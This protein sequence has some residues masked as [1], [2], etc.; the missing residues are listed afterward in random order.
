MK[1]KPFSTIIF[2]LLYVF[3]TI[4]QTPNDTLILAKIKHVSNTHSAVSEIISNLSDINGPRL[5]GTLNYYKS[6]NFAKQ[7]LKTSGADTVYFESFD[8]QYRGWTV[9]SFNMEMTKPS[10]MHITAYP[11]A[12]TKST[13]GTVEGDVFYCSNTDSLLFFKGKLKGKIVLLGK[14]PLNYISAVHHTNM[15]VAEYVNEA[16]LKE[17]AVV[18][19]YLIYKVAMR[20]DLLPR[21]DFISIK[22]NL[23]GKT[24]FF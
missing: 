11:L 3:K 2:L 14:T 13:K 20:D 24:T 17:N 15:D 19:A 5:L 12:Y 21:R 8:N 10:Y 1:N 16:D 9:K 4:G 18:V 22:P 23:Q 7:K 6:A